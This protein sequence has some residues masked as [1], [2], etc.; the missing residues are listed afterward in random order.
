MGGSKPTKRASKVNDIC[1]PLMRM[2]LNRQRPNDRIGLQV[3]AFYNAKAG[4]LS[5]GPVIRFHK[6]KDRTDPHADVT[7]AVVDYCPFCGTRVK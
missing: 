4:T 7:Y 3:A 6:S 2:A 5:S 1:C